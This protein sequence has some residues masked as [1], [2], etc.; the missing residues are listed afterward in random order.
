[1]IAD[2]PTINVSKSRKSIVSTAVPL[3]N[4]SLF[5]NIVHFQ[6]ID[7]EKVEA[8]FFFYLFNI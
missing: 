3:R 8:K 2:A 6:S 1:M 5:K 4:I 7:K